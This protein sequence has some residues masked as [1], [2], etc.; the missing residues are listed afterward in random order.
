[1]IDD[2]ENSSLF[3]GLIRNIVSYFPDAFITQSKANDHKKYF[4]GKLKNKRCSEFTK[5]QENLP[6]EVIPTRS[7]IL[8]AKLL[9]D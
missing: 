9:N 4:W 1:M 6:Q 8:C 5:W 3:S 7:K 2:P